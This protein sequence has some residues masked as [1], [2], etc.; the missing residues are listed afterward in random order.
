MQSDELDLGPEDVI[1]RI[2]R[3][4]SQSRFRQQTLENVRR[5]EA[6]IDSSVGTLQS[7]DPAN[8]AIVQTLSALLIGRFSLGWSHYVALL[9]N[10]DAEARKFEEIEAADNG[11]SVD[12]LRRQID[13]SLYQ[14]LALNKVDE[15]GSSGHCRLLIE[16]DADYSVWSRLASAKPL[17]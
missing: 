3:G 12:K 6:S 11:W 7:V 5:N 2:P 16:V 1:S 14:R 17:P 9:S 10:D 4:A 15:W 8:R 13:S